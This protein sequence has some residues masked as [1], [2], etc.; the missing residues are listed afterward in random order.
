LYKN[1]KF[2]INNQQLDKMMGTKILEPSHKIDE[3]TDGVE[4]FDSYGR[5]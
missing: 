1:G 5:K 3:A 4:L 2:E